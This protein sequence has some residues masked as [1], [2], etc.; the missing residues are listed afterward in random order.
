MKTT[1]IPQSRRK[2]MSYYLN[3]VKKQE[4][5][6]AQALANEEAHRR[7]AQKEMEENSQKHITDLCKEVQDSYTEMV[8]AGKNM[9]QIQDELNEKEKEE[10][11]F[12]KTADEIYILKDVNEDDMPKMK[13]RRIAYYGLP[14]LDCI[15]AWFALSPIITA[16][17]GSMGTF[18]TF[19]V[20]A[21]GVLS[22]LFVGYGLSILS[23]IAV[24]SLDD[25][26]SAMRWV[27]KMAIGVSM[28]ILPSLYI[29]SEVCFN[30]GTSWTYSAC[31]AA[32]SFVIQLL[33]VSGYKSHMD[34][35][36]YFRNKK[37][38]DET[39][40]SRDADEKAIREEVKTLRG[41]IQNIM[42]SFDAEYAKFTDSFRDLASARD[43]H[44][45]EFGKDARY[46]LNQLVIYIGDLV[47]FRREVIPLYYEANGSVS[48]IPFVNFHNV[49][50][51]RGIFTNSDFIYLDYMLQ[52][53]HTGVSLTETIR[54]LSKQPY[55]E[56]NSSGSDEDENSDPFQQAEANNVNTTGLHEA[57]SDNDSPGSIEGDPDNGGIW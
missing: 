47:C 13:L 29:V 17:I 46:Y 10:E 32:V 15:F 18:P 5:Q 38:N 11:L 54:A 49:F 7:N 20:E 12:H 30:G 8:N 45:I 41:K 37:Q 51:G 50:G 57:P 24:A 48:T 55:P 25:D 56:L 9:R 22:S 36:N 52:R 27:K 26:R 28:V 19:V 31:F 43:K 16:K 21:I 34:A 1:A 42:T 23:R 33:I 6:E 35:I 2:S 4:A 14:I 39:N 40:A 53:G 3:S 44:I